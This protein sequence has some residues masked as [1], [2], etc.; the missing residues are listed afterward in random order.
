VLGAESVHS[1]SPCN[2]SDPLN[3]CAVLAAAE[4]EVVV[5]ERDE[6][7]GDEHL[8]ERVEHLEEEDRVEGGHGD[9][10]H[11]LR[12]HRICERLQHL[13]E[14]RHHED[15]AERLEQIT[16]ERDKHVLVMLDDKQEIDVGQ[17]KILGL[18]DSWN[19]LFCH[20]LG[21]RCK[22]TST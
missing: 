6:D 9:Q 4:V 11:G 8:Q 14:Q 22:C 12:E 21:G 13:T 3:G 18:G 17:R 19:D 1:L 16:R 2:L 7:E 15:G 10:G 20:L 5:E